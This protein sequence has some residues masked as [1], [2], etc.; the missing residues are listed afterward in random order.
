MKQ[1]QYMVN[2]FLNHCEHISHNNH[3]LPNENALPAIRFEA[4]VEVRQGTG[5]F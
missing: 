2:L 5:R 1:L 4:Q 3:V